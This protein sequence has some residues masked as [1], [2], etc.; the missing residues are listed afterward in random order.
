MV[1]ILIEVFGFVLGFWPIYVMSLKHLKISPLPKQT[2]LLIKAGPYKLIRHPM[3]LALLITTIPLAISYISI[4][5][6]SVFIILFCTLLIKIEIEENLIGS[7][8]NNYSG[9]KHNT[10]KLIPYIY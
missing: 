2:F 6:V 7:I 3:Y 1:L 9:Y 10:K 8:N 5:R 4:N